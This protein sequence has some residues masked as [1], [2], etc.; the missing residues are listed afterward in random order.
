MFWLDY[1]IRYDVL[2]LCLYVDKGENVVPTFFFSFLFVLYS[3]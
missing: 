3:F 1:K 2:C